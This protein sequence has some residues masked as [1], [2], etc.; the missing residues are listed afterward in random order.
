MNDYV[1]L[2]FNA[3]SDNELFIRTAASA[4]ALR[5]N[6]TIQDLY[7]IK[8][9]LSEAVTNCIIHAYEENSEGII[10]VEMS[11]ANDELSIRIKDYGCGIEDIN[12]AMEPM[13]TSKPEKERSG[14]GFSIMQSFSDGMTVNS[15]KGEG[16]EVE[17]KKKIKKE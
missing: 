9:I 13:Y 12:Q 17:I 10:E 7:E 3:S 16:T 11:I 6:P 15:K 14:L 4:F 2:T 1:R 8:T 5:L